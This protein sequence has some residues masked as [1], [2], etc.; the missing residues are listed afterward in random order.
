MPGDRAAAAWAMPL[1]RSAVPW[2]TPDTRAA[3]PGRAAEALAEAGGAAVRSDSF[4]EARRAAR[5]PR[6]AS[7]GLALGVGGGDE[8]A[9]EQAD[10]LEEVDL[11]RLALASSVSSQ[12]RWPASVVGISEAARAVEARRGNLPSASIE[13][14]DDLHPG[15]DLHEHLVV[16]P[17]LDR[18]HLDGLV[19][20]RG[21]GVEHGLRR[22]HVALG[23]PQG[24][25]AAA[26]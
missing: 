21:H 5:L 6:H 9:A 19:H 7:D 10:V 1:T 12:N 24:V 18:R 25:D 13:P 11:L 23:R 15:V 8:Q 16:G 3:A 2:A 22:L 17:L 26:G 14:G 4:A 20:R